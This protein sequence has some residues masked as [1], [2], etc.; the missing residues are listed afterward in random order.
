MVCRVIL[1]RFR[2]EACGN[3]KATNQDWAAEA[4]DK[5][6]DVIPQLKRMETGINFN[7]LDWA[8]DFSVT[9]EL[10]A[11]SAIELLMEQPIV[12]EAFE[13][14]AKVSIEKRQI[15]YLF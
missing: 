3:Y 4:F 11:W 12:K 15:D 10:S 13:F 6:A 14:V 2:D 8:S 1:Y 5:I 9:F 7:K